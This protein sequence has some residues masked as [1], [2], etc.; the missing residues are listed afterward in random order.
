MLGTISRLNAELC[1]YVVNDAS[2]TVTTS[3]PLLSCLR[4]E[5][6]L[7]LARPERSLAVA[8]SLRPRQ[9]GELKKT[10]TNNKRTRVLAGARYSL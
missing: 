10:L 7:T 4:F 9:G 2:P 6:A 1:L 8:R 5:T 3:P